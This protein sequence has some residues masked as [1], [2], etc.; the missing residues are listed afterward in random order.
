MRP[1]LVL[2]GL[3]FAPVVHAETTAEAL[4]C[5]PN[6][7]QRTITQMCL[8]YGPDFC[9]PYAGTACIPHCIQR[10]VTGM[11]RGYGPDYCGVYPVCQPYCIQRT[12]GGSCRAYGAD[13]CF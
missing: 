2:I 5:A 11:C 3:L 12:V 13:A 1:L 4:V 8:S 6:C 10:T 9:T 7:T